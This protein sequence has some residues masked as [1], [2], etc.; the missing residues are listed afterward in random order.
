MRFDQ[1]RLQ[2]MAAGLK[3]LGRGENQWIYISIKRLK[4]VR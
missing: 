4:Y 1:K 3:E 2:T